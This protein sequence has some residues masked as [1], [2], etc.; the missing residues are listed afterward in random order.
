ML[1]LLLELDDTL[2]GLVPELY[3]LEHDILRSLSGAGFYHYDRL[4]S[5]DDDHVEL[6]VFQLGQGWI[7]YKLVVYIAYV[8]RAYRALEGHFRNR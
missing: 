7:Q 3:R 4:F 2:I 6:A 5:A 8:D 1:E